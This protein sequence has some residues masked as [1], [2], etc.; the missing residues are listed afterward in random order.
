V[1]FKKRF[2]SV[3][4]EWTMRRS[5]VESSAIFKRIFPVSRDDSDLLPATYQD[6]KVLHGEQEIDHKSK[7]ESQS[8]SI[9]AIRIRYPCGVNRQKGPA[10]TIWFR[11]SR[12]PSLAINKAFK[13]GSFRLPR[14]S[15]ITERQSR[16]KD[17]LGQ[18]K[19][20]RKNDNDGTN[21]RAI[22]SSVENEGVF[23]SNYLA[24]IATQSRSGISTLNLKSWGTRYWRQSAEAISQ[25]VLGCNTFESVTGLDF[26]S[27][28]N[29]SLSDS[30]R[31][32][33]V[34]LRD[35]STPDA[36]SNERPNASFLAD[37]LCPR[38]AFH[39]FLDLRT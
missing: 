2:W 22:H 23:S 3:N 27:I 31:Q 11:V 30:L 5:G 29:D 39:W 10:K 38:C 24:D 36:N 16:P 37:S 26:S 20:Q 35:F 25:N 7:Q 21:L 12:F 34:C 4:R 1:P 8:S 33:G 19:I 18:A 32:F 28:S 15:F 9:G 14:M 6:A 13:Q 17:S